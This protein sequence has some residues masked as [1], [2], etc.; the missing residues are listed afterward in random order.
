MLV[1][2]TW[3]SGK[4]VHQREGT[5]SALN[6]KGTAAGQQALVLAAW[7]QLADEAVITQGFARSTGSPPF[8]LLR[9]LLNEFGL[10]VEREDRRPLPPSLTRRSAK[11]W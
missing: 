7:L 5:A 6:A 2:V 8:G 10:A 9:D 4:V 11:N 1:M 3:H